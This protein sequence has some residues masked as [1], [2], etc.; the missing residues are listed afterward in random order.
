MD[1]EPGLKEHADGKA[2]EFTSG[3]MAT[4]L[5]AARKTTLSCVPSVIANGFKPGIL[6]SVLDGLKE[7]TIFVSN[8]CKLNTKKRW[9]SGKRPKGTIVVDDGAA[10]AVRAH[11]SLLPSGIVRSE[12]KFEEGDLTL[13]VDTRGSEIAMGFAEYA[14]EDVDRIAGKKSAEVESILGYK[15]ANVVVH[16]DNMVIL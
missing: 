2:H 3:G 7:G 9:I 4:K 12:G 5:D 6:S 11:K 8:R 1:T 16:V 15:H 13:I 14:S 10:N